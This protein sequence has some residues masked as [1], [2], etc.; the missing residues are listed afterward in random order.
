MSLGNPQRGGARTNLEGKDPLRYEPQHGISRAPV[1]LDLQPPR[2]GAAMQA[3]D[4]EN[5]RTDANGIRGPC[6]NSLAHHRAQ[7][8]R[9]FDFKLTA[10]IPVAVSDTGGSPAA[11]RAEIAR[12]GHGHRAS[13][14]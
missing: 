13:G 5:L 14:S 3:L 9:A 1:V 8:R 12:A 2:R 11:I 6:Q 10:P 7:F 4:R